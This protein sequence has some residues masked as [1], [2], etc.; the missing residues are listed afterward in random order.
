MREHACE[1]RDF[2]INL[3]KYRAGLTLRLVMGHYDIEW[4]GKQHSGI[5]D[6]RNTGQNFNQFKAKRVCH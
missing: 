1:I 3:A 4:K 6:A 5:D 2:A